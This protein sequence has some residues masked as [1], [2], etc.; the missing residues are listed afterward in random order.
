VTRRGSASA[1]PRDQPSPGQPPALQSDDPLQRGWP[2]PPDH[3][4]RRCRRL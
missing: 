3:P 1:E 4:V 2:V